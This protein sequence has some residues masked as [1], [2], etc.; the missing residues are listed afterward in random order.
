KLCAHSRQLLGQRSPLQETEGR[1]GVHLSV[2]GQPAAPIFAFSSPRVKGDRIY[3]N[4]Y[5]AIIESVKLV[6]WVGPSRKDLKTFPRPARRHI[7]QALYAAQCGEEYPSVKAL[8]GFG[9]RTVLEIVAPDA[10]DPT[11]P[12]IQSASTMRFMFCT[13]FKRSRRRASRRL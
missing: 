12:S 11:E 1:T 4:T 9:G 3:L 8:H 6:R 10:G 2:H 13:P 7:G 5:T